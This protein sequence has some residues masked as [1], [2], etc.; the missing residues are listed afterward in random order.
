MYKT[1]TGVEQNYKIAKY[2]YKMAAK[3][4]NSNSFYNLGYLYYNGY[5]VKE[6][7]K[8]AIKY[9]EKSANLN[10]TYGLNALGYIL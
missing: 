1:G 4:N 9:F 10:N 8:K 7:I 5:G 6:S 2:Y 3:L